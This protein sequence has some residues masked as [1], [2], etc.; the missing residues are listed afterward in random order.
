MLGSLGDLQSSSVADV[1]PALWRAEST[2]LQGE[3]RH[4]GPVLVLL[5]HDSVHFPSKPP[6]EAWFPRTRLY[7]S[8]ELHSA[9]E[10]AR[11]PRGEGTS[12]FPALK[13]GV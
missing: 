11:D 1:G 5:A 7:G 6:S 2:R 3:L 10:D 4:T 12:D 9:K 13:D 8:W